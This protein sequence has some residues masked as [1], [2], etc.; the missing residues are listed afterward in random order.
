MK[1]KIV[2]SAK[3]RELTGKKVKALR[4]EKIVPGVVYGAKQEPINIQADLLAVQRTIAVAGTHTPIE[5]DLGEKKIPAIIKIVDRD[6]RTRFPINVSFQAISADQAIKTEVPIRLVDEEESEAN[7]A[8]LVILQDMEQIEI[9]A[10]PADLPEALLV[11]AKD[12]K[13]HGDRL[14]VSDIIVPEGV[15][16]WIDDQNLPVVS[17]YEPSAIAAANAA[18]DE[19]AKKD[20][21]GAEKPAEEGAETA[22][23]APAEG[24][25]AA[26]K[27]E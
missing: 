17:V 21:E 1:E 8:G 15:E 20:Q 22:S 25:A 9:K 16:I 12:L 19:A 6:N 10:K 5:I 27:A 24:E 23:E 7:K 4:Y 2:L 11:S 14:L 3:T 18:A 26:E 13:E